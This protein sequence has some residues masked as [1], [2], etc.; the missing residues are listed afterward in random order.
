MMPVARCLSEEEEDGLSASGQLK[1][2]LS[3]WI[4]GRQ[5]SKRGKDG[6]MG[7]SAVVPTS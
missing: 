5:R 4:R 3:G 1:L 6:A 2:G 7:G